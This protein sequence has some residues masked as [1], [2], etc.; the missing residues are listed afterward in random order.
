M[1]TRSPFLARRGIAG[2]WRS[3]WS[4][5]PSRGSSSS[6][7][8]RDRAAGTSAPGALRRSWGIAGPNWSADSAAVHPQSRPRQGRPLRSV[9]SKDDLADMVSPL[10]TLADWLRAY[11][12]LVQSLRVQDQNAGRD[13][14]ART[15][16]IRKLD[17][18]FANA[19]DCQIRVQTDSTESNIPCQISR[20]AAND[21]RDGTLSNYTISMQVDIS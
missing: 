8:S 6:T 20:S 4:P 5:H 9:L 13:P 17:R 14:L 1:A 11:D 18:L 15:S 19:F 12:A 10:A 16:E 7:G 3:G 2:R 21:N